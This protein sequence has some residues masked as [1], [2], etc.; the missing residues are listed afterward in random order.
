MLVIHETEPLV[1]G[2]AITAK[3]KVLAVLLVLSLCGNALTL[4][5]CG[6][7]VMKR[8]GFAYLRERF[9]PTGGAIFLGDSMTNLGEWS[10]D[11]RHEIANFGVRGNETTDVIAR[12]PS[13][14]RRHPDT[15]F[16]MVGTND[17]LRGRDLDRSVNAFIETV[18]LLRQQNPQA[19]IYVETVLPVTDRIATPNPLLQGQGRVAAV[20]DWINQFN[21]RIATVADNHS[22]FLIDLHTDFLRDGQLIPEYT[23][24]GIHL[25]ARGY[26]V[27]R[28]D[29][30]PLLK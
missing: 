27:W 12:V 17:A 28:G 15:I 6:Y 11:F 21:R 4:L 23:P 14:T 1:A 18:H 30:L 9:Q 2:E 19:T 13:V 20:N 29:T 7:I 8:G 22:V 24:D 3:R 25:N 26:W 16:F 5:A 10:D